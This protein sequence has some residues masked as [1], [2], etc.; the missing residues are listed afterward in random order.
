MP[1]DRPD[2]PR[3]ERPVGRSTYY[4]RIVNGTQGSDSVTAV[5]GEP[6]EPPTPRRKLRR[7]RL[8]VLLVVLVGM[9]ALAVLGGAGVFLVVYDEATKIDR[10]APDAAVDNYLRAAFVDRDAAQVALF[11]CKDHTNSAQI[12]ALQNELADRERESGNKVAVTWGALSVQEVPGGHRSVGVDLTIASTLNG[13]PRARR[14]EA[15]SFDVADQDGW[16]VC[17]ATKVS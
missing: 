12:A 10:T 2:R 15:W 14:V 13:Q 6:P 5:L 7:D 3:S 17:G 11:A 16:R 8:R 4:C 9:A 1:P